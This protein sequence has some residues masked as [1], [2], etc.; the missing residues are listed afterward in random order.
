M[1]IQSFIKLANLFK[2]YGF[3]LFLVGGSVRDYLMYNDFQDF[4]CAT[5]AK[6]EEITKL[7]PYKRIFKDVSSGT[8][9]F[10]ENEVD[11]TT[12]RIEDN[13]ID[14]RHPSK[15]KFTNSIEED[16]YRRDFTINALYMDASLNIYDFHNGLKDLKKKELKFIKDPLISIKE[17]PLRIIRAIRFMTTFNFSLNKSTRIILENNA[18]LLKE[19]R[20][21]KIISELN[22]FKIDDK[23]INQILKKY[24]IDK[25]IPLNFKEKKYPRFEIIKNINNEKILIENLNLIQKKHNSGLI[26]E[27][28]NNS[29]DDFYYNNLS[30]S[31]IDKNNKI[32]N[33]CLSLVFKVV[34]LDNYLFNKKKDNILIVSL[35][36]EDINKFLNC[37]YDKHIIYDITLLNDENKRK[38]LN[39][40]QYIFII[41]DIHYIKNL[42]DNQNLIIALPL[43]IDVEPSLSINF[44][45]VRNN[46]NLFIYYTDEDKDNSKNVFD[47]LNINKSSKKEIRKYCYE[48]L[49]SKI[50]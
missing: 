9:I 19:I 35:L 15:I 33:D 32:L 30:F 16:S 29:I 24:N 4:D 41:F 5:D 12:L 46:G 31:I 22:K 23:S 13:Y 38:I 6:I 49:F 42:M 11:I 17:D 39:L 47:L 36:N 3:S 10:D 48:A 28:R 25:Y 37:D 7:L 50:D 8:F 43:F 44:E 2:N 26:I 20:Y 1:K 40:K 27:I 45:K 21:Q 34:G 18:Y 14:H